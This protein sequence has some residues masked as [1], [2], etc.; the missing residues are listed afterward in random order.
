[1]VNLMS[2]SEYFYQYLKK[3]RKAV[4]KNMKRTSRKTRDRAS[5]IKEEIKNI[6]NQLSDNEMFDVIQEAYQ[7]ELKANPSLTFKQ[8]LK[9]NYKNTRFENFNPKQPHEIEQ[10]KNDL[11]FHKD[12][13]KEL[14]VYDKI[15][16]QPN[17]KNCALLPENAIDKMLGELNK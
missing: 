11:Q 4:K 13:L 8:Y 1:M 6:K 14:N 12:L 3:E 2:L 9:D 10:L 7:K 5:N 15:Y 16:L 17:R